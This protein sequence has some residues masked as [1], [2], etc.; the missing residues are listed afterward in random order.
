LGTLYLYGLNTALSESLYT[1][2][3]MLEVT[4]RNRFHG[5]LSEAI[6]ENWF[7]EP[8]FL[9]APRQP[10]QLAK[11][12]DELAED[13]KDLAPGRIVAALTFGFWTAMLSPQ[14]ENLWQTTLHKAARREDG[15]GLRRKDLSG[16]LT[17]IR[18]LRNR[19]AHHEPII[20]WN[21]RKH[22]RNMLQLTRWLSPDAADW[23]AHHS[24][25]EKVYPDEPVK[26]IKK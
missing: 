19:I 16:P 11:A 5:V 20:P 4:M 14:Y 18:V 25:F 7:D 12:K 1:P 23:C 24:R 10:D 13:G 6:C 15:K 17:P 2:L 22:Y 9:A 8:G 21:L 3:Q 26:I